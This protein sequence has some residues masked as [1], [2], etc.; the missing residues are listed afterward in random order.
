MHVYVCAYVR[1]CV[2][3]LVCMCM[4]GG[5]GGGGAVSD[6]IVCICFCFN[7][8]FIFL[9]IMKCVQQGL[10]WEGCSNITLLLLLWW[11][12]NKLNYMDWLA[13]SC[14]V[15]EIKTLQPQNVDIRYKAIQRIWLPGCRKARSGSPAAPTWITAQMCVPS[16]SQSFWSPAFL[17]PQLPE[18]QKRM[19]DAG[20]KI[21]TPLLS[22]DTPGKA[23][24]EV[25][26]LSDPVSTQCFLLCSF[27]AVYPPLSLFFFFFFFFSLSVCL[28]PSVSFCLPLCLSVSLSLSVCLSPSLCVTVCLPLCLSLSLSALI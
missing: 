20:Q 25:V 6:K 22:L 2:H 3:I 14:T 13:C 27:L 19:E 16:L 28:S 11:W 8:S 1:V 18:I 9:L 23:T 24:V 26:I 5:G 21:L 12:R 17:C 7:L 4:L 10:T 15:S